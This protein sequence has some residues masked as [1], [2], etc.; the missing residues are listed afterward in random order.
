MIL[1]PAIDLKDGACVR[2]VQGDMAAATRYN[3][4]P[5]AQ[6]K[7]FA[8]AGAEWLHVVDLDGAV[9]GRAVNGPAVHAILAAVAIP[10]QLGGGIRDLAA[11]EAWLARGVAR[12]VLGTAAVADPA[13]VREACRRHPGQVALAI[14]ARAGVVAIEG[15][16]KTAALDPIELARRFEDAGLAAVVFTDIERDGALGGVNLQATAALAR[17]VRIPVIASGGVASLAD[18]GA[19]KAAER[20][21]IAGV[22]C[23]RAL[24]DGGL[25]LGAALALLRS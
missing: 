21:G 16:T 18:L 11:V 12:V 4:D 19:L 13:L 8:A 17:A 22:I 3:P 6:A 10:C 2:L 23:G 9:A 25:D 1:Y 20:S 14:D 7:A 15:W 5:A 24:Y